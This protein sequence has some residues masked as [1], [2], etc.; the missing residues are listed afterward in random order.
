MY[1]WAASRAVTRLEDQVAREVKQIQ[2]GLRRDEK[3]LAIQEERLQQA[4]G[5]AELA[6]VKFQHGLA[7]NFDLVQAEVEVRGAQ[8]ALVSLALRYL[9]E[10][11]RLRA[12]LGTLL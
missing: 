10:T 5:Q 3:R 11:Y 7:N 12:A 4:L 9:R 1:L 2:R 8:G 6:Q